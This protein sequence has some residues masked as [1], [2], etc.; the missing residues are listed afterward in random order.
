VSAA[1][2]APAPAQAVAVP[3]APID[4][5]VA[6]ASAAPA[7]PAPAAAEAPGGFSPSERATLRD[8]AQTAS[9]LQRWT[10]LHAGMSQEDVRSRLGAP[11]SVIP[12]DH[13]TGWIYRYA[14]AGTGSVFFDHSGRVIS[15]LAP[16]QGA[17]HLY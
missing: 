5:S 7:V 1:S 11:Q 9:A 4:A 6:P 13:R 14:R 16:G 15:L 8:Q 3:V 17:L 10:E 12:V 2:I